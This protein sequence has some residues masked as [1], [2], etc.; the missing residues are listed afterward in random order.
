MNSPFKWLHYEQALP[1]LAK[2]DIGKAL[3][4]YTT[5]AKQIEAAG[6][7]SVV[8]ETLGGEIVT[9]LTSLL[10]SF[11]PSSVRRLAAIASLS[12]TELEEFLASPEKEKEVLTKVGR[13][14]ASEV[15]A[16]VLFFIGVRLNLGPPSP[17]SSATQMAQTSVVTSTS[18][19][20]AEPSLPLSEVG[21]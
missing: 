6:S 15:I 3:R 12:I 2:A 7:S 14:E 18:D 13:M 1:I 20:S 5:L 19:S 10:Q 8:L 17:G 4:I 9:E 16:L 21:T 11:D